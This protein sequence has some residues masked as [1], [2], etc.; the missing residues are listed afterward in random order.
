MK[1][2]IVVDTSVFMDAYA[3]GS[4][5][6]DRSEQSRMALAT[7][8]DQFKFIHSSNTARETIYMVGTYRRRVAQTGRD[9]AKLKKFFANGSKQVHEKPAPVR[10]HD[11][12]D[13]MFLDT[14]RGGQAK[15]LLTND[16]DLW[17]LRTSGQTLILRPP[18]F[19]A[20]FGNDPQQRIN[21]HITS[22]RDL[23]REGMVGSAVILSKDQARLARELADNMPGPRQNL[24][25]TAVE[26]AAPARHPAGRGNPRGHTLVVSDM[27]KG[28]AVGNT[29]IMSPALYTWLVTHPQ[30]P[31]SQHMLGQ[32]AHCEKVR[33]LPLGLTPPPLARPKPG[34]RP[35]Y[36]TFP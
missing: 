25:Q 13:Q 36:V 18:Q 17:G 32:A 6:S 23:L 30:D 24:P 22:N 35:S 9:Y 11:K 20:L 21:I 12:D 26:V 10:C 2:P 3:P 34:R 15:V 33:P 5:P 7:A 19:N 16:Q 8:K 4:N 14:A 28:N 27:L 31:R 29:A 1:P